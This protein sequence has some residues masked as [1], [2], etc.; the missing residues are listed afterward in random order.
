MAALAIQRITKDVMR[1]ARDS[2]REQERRYLPSA[3]NRP[4]KATISWKLE[5]NPNRANSWEYRVVTQK[6]II[7]PKERS[8]RTTLG[9]IGCYAKVLERVFKDKEFKE[10]ADLK[11]DG[12]NGK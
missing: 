1:E 2:V 11:T 5:K 10:E 8:R 6:W 4:G 3:T 9:K 12:G 7:S